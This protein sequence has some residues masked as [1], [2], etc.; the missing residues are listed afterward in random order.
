M[1]V[2]CQFSPRVQPAVAFLAP[3]PPLLPKATPVALSTRRAEL[4]SPSR[5]RSLISSWLAGV[6]REQYQLNKQKSVQVTTQTLR[7]PL[8][9]FEKTQLAEHR[10]GGEA[11]QEAGAAR[12]A[13]GLLCLER[14]IPDQILRGLEELADNATPFKVEV[15]RPGGRQ[16]GFDDTDNEGEGWLDKLAASIGNSSSSSNA[17][18][19]DD[20]GEERRSENVSR[21]RI[22]EEILQDGDSQ[23]HPKL[24]NLQ[25]QLDVEAQAAVRWLKADIKRVARIFA[26]EI[27]VLTDEICEETAL[28]SSAME[29]L[30]RDESTIDVAVKLELLKRGKCPRFHLD[31]VPIRLICTYVGPSTEWLD[32]Y[33]KWEME[34]NR[35]MPPECNLKISGRREARRARPGDVLIFRGKPQGGF[36]KGGGGG[37]AFAVAHRSPDTLEGQRRLL[38]TLDAGDSMTIPKASVSLA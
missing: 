15:L 31:K 24:P 6:D 32:V 34:N 16:G 26:R 11:A 29:P 12:L 7:T 8:E 37:G 5:H 33:D 20:E 17:R 1:E 2:P 4:R 22:Q 23:L 21:R 14:P 30:A 19:K 13:A 25:Q 9:S 18:R 28:F 10:R 3:Q 36:A 35:S 27:S 38:L